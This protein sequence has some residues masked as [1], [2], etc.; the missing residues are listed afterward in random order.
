LAYSLSKD[1]SDWQTIRIKKLDTGGEYT[2]ILE[3]C[4]NSNIAWT[5][6]E[7]GFF[8]N[9]YPL[10]I[11]NSKTAPVYDNKVYYHKLG[12]SQSKDELTIKSSVKRNLIYTPSISDDNKYLILT[13]TKGTEPKSG[14]I[15]RK[16][17]SDAP[18]KILIP[19]RTDNYSFIGNLG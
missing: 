6:D 14:V 12:T 18:F 10:Q 2:E 5:K 8:Y 3:G 1:G 19:E 16:L 4:R 13:V 9:S 15:Y 7:Q 17:D 11:T